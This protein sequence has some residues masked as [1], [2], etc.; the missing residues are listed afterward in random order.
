MINHI[1]PNIDLSLYPDPL[2]CFS[3]INLVNQTYD[4]IT[5]CNK[6]DLEWQKLVKNHVIEDVKPDLAELQAEISVKSSFN[7]FLEPVVGVKFEI[8][9]DIELKNTE[10]VN[11]DENQDFKIDIIE[12]DPL[13]LTEFN[14]NIEIKRENDEIRPSEAPFD[15]FQLPKVDNISNK[16]TAATLKSKIK[17]LHVNQLEKV[18]LCHLCG[19]KCSQQAMPKHIKEHDN[20]CEK[21]KR[22]F[23]TPQIFQEHQLLCSTIDPKS[24]QLCTHC[25]KTFPNRTK[26]KRHQSNVNRIVAENKDEIPDLIAC[27]KCLKIFPNKESRDLH[28]RNT[29]LRHEKVFGFVC[30]VCDLKITRIATLLRHLK[31]HENKEHKT[32]ALRFHCR[33]CKSKFIYRHK[34]EQHMAQKHGAKDENHVKNNQKWTICPYCPKKFK[35]QQHYEKHLKAFH[36]YNE[37]KGVYNI[38]CVKCHRY[39][40]DTPSLNKH[41]LHMHKNQDKKHKCPICTTKYKS[42]SL[43]N[44]H[45]KKSHLSKAKSLFYCAYCKVN[46]TTINQFKLHIDNEHIEDI[47]YFKCPDCVSTFW[48]SVSLKNHCTERHNN[49]SKVDVLPDFYCCTLCNAKYESEARLN[50]HLRLDH[51]TNNDKNTHRCE[52]CNKEFAWKYCL[53]RH[54]VKEHQKNFSCGLC[55]EKFTSENDFANHIIS[56]HTS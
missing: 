51:K 16:R 45:V 44:R 36:L 4:F 55:D 38:C 35:L 48:F 20:L 47:P 5:N 12:E 13:N 34:L 19:R 29:K 21:C 2:L 6:A 41:T 52:I 26:F 30:G 1:L 32:R 53:T 49:F 23:S 31:Q 43:V 18:L 25:G 40:I 17:K 28:E 24:P 7:E 46:F 33:D 50:D 15:I 54:M 27:K 10:S 8:S 14:G 42:V 3:C 37:E 56:A 22:T 9:S 11:R 39:F